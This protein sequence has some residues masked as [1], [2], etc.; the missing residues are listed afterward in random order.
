MYTGPSGRMGEPEDREKFVPL[1]ADGLTIYVSREIMDGLKPH[2]SKI[3]VAVSGFGRFW[4]H[5]QG[6]AADTL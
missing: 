3:L 5:L 6:T 1:E 2:Q 4:I